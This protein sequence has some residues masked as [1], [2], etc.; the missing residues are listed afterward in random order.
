MRLVLDKSRYE[1]PKGAR[2]A[3][4]CRLEACE[5]EVQSLRTFVPNFSFGPAG[6]VWDLLHHGVTYVARDVQD[7]LDRADAMKKRARKLSR[8]VRATMEF[9]GQDVVDV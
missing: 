6:D 2:F 8:R 1:T 4:A 7:V 5:P 9:D 3:L